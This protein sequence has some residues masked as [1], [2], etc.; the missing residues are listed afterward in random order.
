MES[1]MIN[2]ILI[3]R[4]H[5]IVVEICKRANDKEYHKIKENQIFWEN[6][7]WVFYNDANFFWSKLK[8][9]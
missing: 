9:I 5:D 6:E 2:W 3:K 1:V 4:Y 8:K 7:L